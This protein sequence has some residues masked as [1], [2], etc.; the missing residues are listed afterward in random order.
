MQAHRVSVRFLRMGNNR[1]LGRLSV[2][3]RV[4][5]KRVAQRQASEQLGISEP[6]ARSA[7]YRES[8]ALIRLDNKAAAQVLYSVCNAP[9]TDIFSMCELSMYKSIRSCC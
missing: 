7:W 4:L 8:V 2:V 9:V 3:Q 6:M 1:E 5:D